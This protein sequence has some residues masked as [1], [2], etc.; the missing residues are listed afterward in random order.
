MDSEL[1]VV[2]W[3]RL[4]LAISGFIICFITAGLGLV[5]L[6]R[7]QKSKFIHQLEVHGLKLK[8]P[9]FGLT[10]LGLSAAFGYIS[11]KTMPNLRWKGNEVAFSLPER[12]FLVDLKPI[13]TN[14]TFASLDLKDTDQLR[15]IFLQSLPDHEKGREVEIKGEAV[16]SIAYHLTN[17]DR[18]KVTYLPLNQDGK[19]VFEPLGLHVGSGYGVELTTKFECKPSI[20]A[21]FKKLNVPSSRQLELKL[22]AGILS[23]YCKGEIESL[24]PDRRDKILKLQQSIGN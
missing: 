9:S 22:H 23:T 11:S 24:D 17:N 12:R 21:F 5:S 15:T 20:D 19:L 4:V 6:L 10:L 7:P 14:K 18:S 3:V 16:P 1:K 13:Q 8:T 2:F